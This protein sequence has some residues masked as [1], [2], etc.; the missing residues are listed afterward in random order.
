MGYYTT[1]HLLTVFHLL[2]N[3][4]NTVLIPKYGAKSTNKYY[5]YCFQGNI[6][7]V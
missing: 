3:Q 7:N 6:I 1:C 4:N 5:V 2:S